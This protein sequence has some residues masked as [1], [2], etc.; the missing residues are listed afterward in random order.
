MNINLD[1][2]ITTTGFATAACAVLALFT[3]SL[4][5]AFGAAGCV[6]VFTI[7][8]LIEKFWPEEFSE[9]VGAIEKGDDSTNSLEK[10]M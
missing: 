3:N 6:A 10:K 7:G 9:V 4:W 2:I 1:W 8:I 5:L